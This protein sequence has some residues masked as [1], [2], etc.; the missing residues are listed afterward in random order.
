[1]RGFDRAFA[2]AQAGKRSIAADMKDERLAS[3][4]TSLLEWADVVSHN[5]RAGV[6]DRLDLGYDAVRSVNPDIIYLDAPG[7]G[8]TGPEIGRQSFAPLMSG[9]VGAA[10]ELGGE[11]NPPIYPAANED[12]G[13]GMLGAVAILMALLH[14]K[15]SG[16]GQFVELPQLNSTMT[17]VAH[18]IRREDGSV[19]TERP[20]DPL[21]YGRGPLRRLYPTADGWLFLMAATDA[22][23]AALCKVVPLEPLERD[24]LRSR[25]RAIKEDY[26][27][28]QLLGRYLAGQ[29]TATVLKEL[30]DAGVPAAVPVMDGNHLMLD[31]PENLRIGRVGT[32]DHPRFGRVR[33]VAA[34]FRIDGTTIPEHRRAPELGEHTDAILSWAGY[35]PAEISELRAR[36]AVR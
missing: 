31:D 9:Y 5:L 20:L 3:L 24:L 7:W 26:R 1:M 13:A 14:R 34:P 4:R 10:F 16:S 6:A 23:I 11:F 22:D 12:S 18:I 28:E 29:E 27:V 36:G 25:H 33:E 8:S 30:R 35:P 17:D 19:I 21:Q 2:A 15:R 32:F